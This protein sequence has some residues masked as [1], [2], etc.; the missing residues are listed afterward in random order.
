MP[1]PSMSLA[2]I[3]ILGLSCLMYFEFKP[4]LPTTKSWSPSPSKSAAVIPYQKPDNFS[5]PLFSKASFLS[6]L[7]NVLMPIHSPTIIKSNVLSLLIS[8][9]MAFVT[10]PIFFISAGVWLVN[11]PLPSFTNKKD[12]GISP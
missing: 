2:Y 3:R 5:R 7:I 10:M 12:S 11:L 8:T 9:Q 1:F 6:L 4:K